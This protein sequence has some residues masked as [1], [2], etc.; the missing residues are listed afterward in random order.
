MNQDLEAHQKYKQQETHSVKQMQKWIFSPAYNF[1]IPGT[2]KLILSWMSHSLD[3]NTKDLLSY[4][5][6]VVTQ[7]QRWQT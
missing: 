2:V 7:P 3:L 4:K 5:D 1:A 6:K